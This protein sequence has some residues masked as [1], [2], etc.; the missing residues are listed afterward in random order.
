MKLFKRK[1]TLL[2]ISAFVMIFPF[3]V[4]AADLNTAAKTG[5]EGIIGIGIAIIACII[6]AFITIKLTKHNN[7]KTK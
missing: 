3:S 6:T 1:L 2:L 7:K 5:D 4:K